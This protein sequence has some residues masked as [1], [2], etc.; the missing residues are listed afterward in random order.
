VRIILKN[1]SPRK[2]IAFGATLAEQHMRDLQ[3]AVADRTIPQGEIV[4]FDFSEIEQVNGSYIKGTAL[5]AFL[6]GQM[7]V[8]APKAS[9]PPRHLTDLRPYDLHVAV[10]GLSPDVRGEFDDFLA[11]RG[12]P[13]LLAKRF[14]GKQL[15][16]AGLIGHLDETLR[17][18][19]KIV[20]QKQGAT[21]PNLH[22]LYPD[23]KVTVTA[24]NNRLNDLLALRLV[25]RMKDGRGWNYQPL[26]KKIIWD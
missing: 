20:T 13:M 25:R 9:M 2:S 15:F 23:E 6:C 14:D 5:W 12:I 18:T 4:I 7:A 8:N 26:T 21:A 16:E 11:P 19:L 3:Q 10:S 22:S 24:W 17:S 1:C